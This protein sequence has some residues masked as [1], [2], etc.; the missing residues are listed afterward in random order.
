MRE[1]KFRAWYENHMLTMPMTNAFGRERFF[2]F[3]DDS[4]K[5]MQYTGLKDK[6]GVEI[7]EGDILTPRWKFE[8]IYFADGFICKNELPSN[9]QPLH[10]LLRS[11]EVAGDPMEIIGNIYEN[12]ELLENT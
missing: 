6:N 10:T 4:A 11:R 12:P 5:L 2:G 8:V 1:I 7:Y 9:T 3:I